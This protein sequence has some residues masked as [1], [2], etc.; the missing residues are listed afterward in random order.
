MNV[1]QLPDIDFVGADKENVVSYLMKTYTAI[2]GRTLGKAD[3]VRLFI[4]VIASV[5]IMLL[6]KINYTGKQNLLK[7]AKD[8]IWII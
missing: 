2:T 6:N 8:P 4:L 7:Y 3:P 1:S 5:V